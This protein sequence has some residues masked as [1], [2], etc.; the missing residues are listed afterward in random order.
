MAPPDMQD[1]AR[2]AKLRKETEAVLA[3]TTR[4]SGGYYAPDATET[5]TYHAQCV[6]VCFAG[7][8]GVA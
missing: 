2:E 4:V 1:L 6:S 7:V 3:E 8:L 5:P